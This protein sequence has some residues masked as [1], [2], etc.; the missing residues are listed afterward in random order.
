MVVASDVALS[1]RIPEERRREGWPGGMAI[2][3][4]R[5]MVHYYRATPDGRIA[6]GKGGGRL[7]FVRGSVTLCRAA[8]PSSPI[9]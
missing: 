4:S 3:D 6:F 9:W 1:N 2:S 7:A 5:L 8:R